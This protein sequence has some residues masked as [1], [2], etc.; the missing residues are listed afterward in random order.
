VSARHRLVALGLVVLG[1]LGGVALVAFAARACPGELP[2]Q[3]CPE[4]TI[5]RVV[6]VS[7]A[8]LSVG[9]LVTPL[10]FL[11]EF[12]MS[13]RIAYR[14]AWGRAVRRGLLAAGIVV[15][16]AGLKLGGA[17]SVAGAIFVVVL[18]ALVEWFAL[19]R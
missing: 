10:L 2:G 3:L 1:L 13:R 15:A 12:L 17:L 8:G 7:L 16:L 11:A 14:G 6:V 18:A 19:R 5:N 9:L 4:M